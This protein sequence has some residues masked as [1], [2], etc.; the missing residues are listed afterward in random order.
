[1]SGHECPIV[2]LPVERPMAHCSDPSY[3]TTRSPLSP[4][5]EPRPADSLFLSSPSLAL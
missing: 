3:A 5:V 4:L 1:M 2:R